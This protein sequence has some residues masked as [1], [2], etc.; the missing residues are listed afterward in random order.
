MSLLEYLFGRPLATYEEGE[1]RVG[2]LA[3]IPMLGLDA[4]S[5]AAYG[6]EAALTLLIPLGAAGRRVHRSDQH[7]DHRPAGNR[8][9]FVSP[10]DRRRIRGGGSYTVARENLGTFP[11]LLAAAALMLDYVLVVAVGI[12]AG[13][14]ALVSACPVSAPH[15]GA[16]SVIL[17]LITL[18]N[19]R[20]VASRVW[21]SWLRLICSSFRCSRFWPS[22]RSRRAGRRPSMPVRT[23]APSAA[24]DAGDPLDPDARVCQRLHGD[25]RRRGREQRRRRLP[26]ASG[27]PRPAHAD[28]RSSRSWPSCWRASPILPA[29]GIGATEPGQA[30]YQSILSQLVAAVIGRGLFYYVTIGSVLSVLALSANTA[31]PTSPGFAGSSPRT[32]SCPW[33]RPSRAPAGLLQGIVVLA[34]LSGGLLI[35]FAGITDNLIPL[36]AVGAFLAFTLSQAGMVEHWRRW[37]GRTPEIDGD[38]WRGGRLHGGHA[39]HRA[40]FQVRRRRLG[41]DPAGPVTWFLFNIVQAHYR[42]VGREVA[43]DCPSTSKDLSRRSCCCRF[44]AGVPSPARRSGSRSRSRLRSTRFISRATSSDGRAGRRLETAG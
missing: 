8:L 43:T 32:A 28:A 27:R 16:V 41:R 29:Y 11:G 40:G 31:S 4:L 42:T 10:D 24:P 30:G 26:R 20:G 18:V 6:P 38:Q 3:S 14:G 2:V 13:V 44:G 22:A 15:A 12:S 5:S 34:I 35:A 19:L 37:E 9:L 17:A 25:D 23:A 1:Q 39:R 7:A 36:F 21:R 33:L